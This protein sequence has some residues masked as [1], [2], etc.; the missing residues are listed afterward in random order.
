MGAA[1]RRARPNRCGA[2][3]DRRSRVRSLSDP[4][5]SWP[6]DRL[7]SSRSDRLLPS[8]ESLHVSPHARIHGV[9]RYRSAPSGSTVTTGLSRSPRIATRI[10]AT[11]LVPAEPPTNSPLRGPGGAPSRNSR[12]RRR[13]RPR[14]RPIDRGS[15]AAHLPRCLRPI[16]ALG[17]DTSRL[18]PVGEPRTDRIGENDPALAT[19]RWRNARPTPVIVPPV[20]A[21]ATN[22]PIR[23][24]VCSRISTA[25]VSRARVRSPR[26][27][28]DR[29]GTSRSP[30]R[31]DRRPRRKFSGARRR[32]VRR[33]HDP[34]ARGS[35]ARTRLSTD[36]FSGMTHT[37]EYPRTA[38]TIARPR[39]YCPRSPRSASCRAAA[40]R[41]LPRPR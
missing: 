21:P 24:S 16:A 26:C 9:A 32:R 25:V 6:L 11:T 22:A 20:P 29:Q 1:K 38:A 28:T 7:S 40:H 23:P 5:A 12:R 4:G 39:R 18:D 35:R 31:D 8:R 19:P 3:R 14:R 34:R 15:P 10:A 27:G 33:D 13:A 41:V 17:S 37:S 36:I 2:S 30:R